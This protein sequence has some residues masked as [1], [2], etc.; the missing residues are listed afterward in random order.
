MWAPSELRVEGLTPRG[1][2]LSLPGASGL[3]IKL[4]PCATVRLFAQR[5]GLPVTERLNCA[6]ASKRS[7]WTIKGA[8]WGGG[9]VGLIKG[10]CRGGGEVGFLVQACV[11]VSTSSA[12]S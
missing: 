11:K 10:A 12:E 3:Q 5:T 1:L 9:E 6:S 7:W 4:R 2:E 8:W